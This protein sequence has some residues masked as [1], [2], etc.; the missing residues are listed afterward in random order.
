MKL[1]L[2]V[3]LSGKVAVVT[4]AGGVICSY[5]SEIMAAAGAKVALLDINEEA[6]RMVADKITAK[7]GAAIGVGCDVLNGES[8]KK[9][10]KI[11]LEEFGKCN[12]LL[13]GAGGNHPK[14][15]TTSE[16]FSKDQLGKEKTFFDIEKEG[17]DYVF[18]LNFTGTFL[19][20]QEFARDMIDGGDN[21]II[22]IASVNT[23]LPL[24]KI[25]AY[26]AAKEAIG[27]FTKWLATYFSGV[28]IRVN[29]IAPGFL[30]TSQTKPLF[31]QEDGVTP[32]PRLN[33]IIAG[34]PMG[35]LGEPEELAGALLYLL[36]FEASSFVT[37]TV[38]TVDGGY[39]A[40][41]GV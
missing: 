40:Y 41:S 38:I 24:T 9:A 3:D 23:Y 32:T 7:G 39:T 6:A 1:P 10:H 18:G 4:G 31:Y 29:A 28:G 2:N 27:N 26:A 34:T 13:N 37:G 17:F 21:T 35:R 36:C 11:V 30:A 33:K 8:I 20:T 19:P 12:I 14:A 15:T 22:N 25:P 5:L 16:I